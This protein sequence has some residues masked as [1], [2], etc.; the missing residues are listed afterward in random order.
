MPGLGSSTMYQ[1]M[2]FIYLVGYYFQL[3]KK[4]N[5]C[6][7]SVLPCKE[8]TVHTVRNQSQSTSVTSVALIHP[9]RFALRLCLPLVQDTLGHHRRRHR[10]SKIHHQVSC[11][12]HQQS[13]IDR[14]TIWPFIKM[15]A[16][17]LA[18]LWTFP[19]VGYKT[20]GTW[21]LSGLSAGSALQGTDITT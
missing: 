2:L 12:H 4:P 19:M 3:F 15:A 20:E 14:S 21:A 6:M 16:S 1:V 7:Q 9:F 8:V 18:I 17:H 10:P 11:P 5:S 13:L